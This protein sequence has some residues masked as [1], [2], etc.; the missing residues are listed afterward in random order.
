[1]SGCH[2][3]GSPAAGQNLSA[4]VAYAQIV[5][6][7]SSE[8]PSLQRINPGNAAQSYMIQ[9]LEGTAG[10]TGQRMPFGGPYLPQATIDRIRAWVDAG[11]PN[12]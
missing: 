9:K 2:T 10:I 11:A 7:A 4:G 5:G 3:G 6:V 1:M 8:V 12:N